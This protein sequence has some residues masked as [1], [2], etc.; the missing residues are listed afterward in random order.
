VTS[1]LIVILALSGY[2]FL[3]LRR[4]GPDWSRAAHLQLT[5]QAGTEFYPNLA[6]DGKSF[7]YSSTQSGN[8]DIWVQRVGG[9]NP[10][11]LTEN[12]PSNDSQPV[13]SPDGEQIAFRSDR[14]PA[15]I[16]V[17]GATGENVK[18]LV[19]GGYHPAWSPDGAEI[20]Y[21]TLGKD[22]PTTR[23]TVPSSIWIINVQ[24]GAKRQIT[25]LDAMQPSWSPDGKRLAFWYMPPALGRSDVATISVSGGEPVVVTSDALANWNPVWSPDGK[26]LYFASDRG[27]NMSFW[28]VSIDQTTGKVL[29]EPEAIN[30]PSKYSRH[31]NFSR[32]GK[33]MIY[34]ET[35]DRQNIMGALFDQQGEKFVDQPY[36]ITTGDR[37]VVLPDL[38]PDGKRF[39][40]RL[41]RRNQEDLALVDRDGNNWQDLTNDKFFDRYP[42]WSPDGKKVVFNSDRL[43]IYDLWM[44]DADGTNL[45]QISINSKQTGFPIF[46]PDGK[47]LMFRIHPQAAV[48]DLSK[49]WNEQTPT[50]L[51]SYPEE[52]GYFVGWDWSPDG[53]KVIGGIGGDATGIAYY[54]FETNTYTKVFEADSEPKWLADSRR[55]LFVLRGK[56]CIL[57]IYTKKLH[58]L[59]QR[60]RE[61]ISSVGISKDNTFI[62]FVART[63]ES[64]IWLLD[65]Q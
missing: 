26:F 20:A 28:R 38:S 46:S 50:F 52:N 54:S 33:R 19:E 21:S 36:W 41:A 15:G 58:E 3:K 24:T 4:A 31:L 23:N 44:I 42:R 35:D 45:K 60:D 57:D 1:A 13:F 2:W 43:G 61:T 40:M 51:P 8:L 47:R 6:P 34:V 18:R 12:T 48:I 11:C 32:D 64:D 56:I 7:V 39:V 22:L 53:T 10:R 49:G 27:G 55:I 5:Q 29:S 30:T 16:Y 59:Y 25:T 62:Y 9:K 14:Q 37:R 17:M 65:L 63:A